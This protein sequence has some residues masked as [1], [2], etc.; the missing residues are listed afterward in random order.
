MEEMDSGGCNAGF[1]RVDADL[2]F[3]GI[4]DEPEQSAYG[5]EHYYEAFDGYLAADANQT[6]NALGGDLCYYPGAAFYNFDPAVEATGGL[7]EE[8]CST[9]WEAAMEGLAKHS[10]GRRHV[11][12][13]SGQAAMPPVVTVDGI[14]AIGTWTYSDAD[15]T[16]RF[17]KDEAPGPGQV[18]EVDYIS[19]SCP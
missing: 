9:N 11:Y 1:R 15:S 4:A 19:S 10:V 8:L 7:T 2:V 13:L 16:L 6:Y 3:W 17:E 5:W 12:T 18:V 14:D